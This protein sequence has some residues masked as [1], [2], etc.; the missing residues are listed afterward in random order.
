MMNELAA[1]TNMCCASCGK[2]EVDDVKL[3]KCAC[4]LVRYCSVDCQKNH[5]PQH[6][7]ACKKRIAETRDDNLFRQPDECYLG[8]CPICCLPLPIDMS[9]SSINACCCKVVCNGCYHANTKR[10]IE[11]EMVQKCPFC[12]EIRPRRQGESMKQLMKRVKTNDPVALCQM[13]LR[14]QRDGNHERAIEYLTKAVE[15]DDVEAHYCLS[16]LYYKGE[17]VEKD[18]KKEV[19]HLEQAALAGHPRARYDLGCYEG[20]NGRYER[21]MK[22]F[23]IAA[24]LGYDDALEKV[25]KGFVR[26]YVSK[27]DYAAALRGHQTAVDATKS[28]QREIAAQRRLDGS[29]P[30]PIT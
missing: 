19:Y 29:W 16:M 6:K 15:L 14:C 1:T 8:D 23:I 18:T 9:K 30:K 3:K 24:N 10:E 4:L 17:G 26:G 13:G 21:A 12:R 11:G 2:A 5:R 7:K 25:K 20:R 22:H 28:P 27:E